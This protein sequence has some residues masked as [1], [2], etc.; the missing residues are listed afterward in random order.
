MAKYVVTN[1]KNYATYSHM[2]YFKFHVT[3]VFTYCIVS[4]FFINVPQPS[5]SYLHCQV[6]RDRSCKYPRLLEVVPSSLWFS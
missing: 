5:P 4:R 3:A 6:R 2:D 1:D